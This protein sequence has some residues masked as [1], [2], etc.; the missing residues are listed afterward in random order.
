MIHVDEAEI[1]AKPFRSTCMSSVCGKVPWYTHC[2]TFQALGWQW[3]YKS[4]SPTSAWCSTTMPLG[5]MLLHSAVDLAVTPKPRGTSDMEKMTTP[6]LLGVLSVILP[7]PDLRTWLPYRSDI[8]AA[9]FT[10]TCKG[11]LTVPKGTSHGDSGAEKFGCPSEVDI[12]Y[13]QVQFEDWRYVSH[14]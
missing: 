13:M 8:S 7:K 3:A 11:R 2:N 1:M 6:V 5:S 10:H 9:G 12:V 4:Y 14:Q